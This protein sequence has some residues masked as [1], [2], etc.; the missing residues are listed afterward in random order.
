MNKRLKIVTALLACS[1]VL[2]T[3]MYTRTSQQEDEELQEALVQSRKES[4]LRKKET[5]RDLL[6]F[7]EQERRALEE[8]RRQAELQKRNAELELQQKNTQTQASPD[9]EASTSP[10]SAPS[11]EQPKEGP[12][13]NA[14]RVPLSDEVV[15]E[16]PAMI[17]LPA[18][19]QTDNS[20]CAYHAVLNAIALNKLLRDG[21]R[22]TNK[23]LN[24]ERAI[25][26]KAASRL[27]GVRGNLDN[28][29]IAEFIVKNQ[30]AGNEKDENV[31]LPGIYIVEQQVL[32]EGDP[33]AFITFPTGNDLPNED[34]AIIPQRIDPAEG[35][36][37]PLQPMI[38]MVYD[39]KYPTINFI[40]R[41]TRPLLAQTL[42]F[43]EDLRAFDANPAIKN[44]GYK[45]FL[46]AGT[47]EEKEAK[48]KQN[49]ELQRSA[50][51]AHWVLL[52][53][54]PMKDHT[55]LRYVYIDSK[56]VPL[57]LDSSVYPIIKELVQR[58]NADWRIESALREQP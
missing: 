18:V 19:Y 1:G 11:K 15:D 21:T 17:Q 58:L 10:K 48:A 39:G 51:N 7:Q 6:V 53:A 29:Q 22:I 14:S 41:K 28:G 43:L 30:F 2:I 24:A 31:D 27:E 26:E 9:V 35:Q 12:Y 38:K 20:T 46:Q 5:Q 34:A 40:I 13:D 37:S 4:I 36:S 54:M 3:N 25:L 56:Q 44:K 45:A 47:Q 52:S 50:G 33:H 16:F 42:Q 32:I 8:S 55:G 49:T 57:T 23:N